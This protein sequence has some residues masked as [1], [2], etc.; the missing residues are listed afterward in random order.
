[1]LADVEDAAEPTLLP[2]SVGGVRTIP[3]SQIALSPHN[4]RRRLASIEELAESVRDYGLLQPV[5]VRSVG[6]HYELIAGHRRLE[7]AR[8]LGWAE[9]AAIERHENAAEAYLLTLIENLQRQDLSPKE[10][11]VAL[12]VL[13]RERSWSV[14]EVA[15]AIKRSP[16]HVSKRLRVFE[17]AMLAPVV[18]ANKLS[19]SAAEELLTVDGKRR[20]DLLARAVEGKWERAQ[21]RQAA[22]APRFAAKQAAPVRISVAR[23]ARELRALLAD[24]RP[25]DLTETDRRELRL[26]FMDLGMVARAKPS[27]QRVFPPL[28]V[29]SRR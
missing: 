29:S 11:A 14:R 13:V 27:A 2:A 10:E 16:A 19:V 3:V 6:D 17:D 4:P 15:S 7:A 21:V 1:M 12:E 24:R 22:N 23:R 18:L 5:V 25:A 26:L 8:L 20:Y 28:P 9:I